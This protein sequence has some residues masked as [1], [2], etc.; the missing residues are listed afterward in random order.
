MGNDSYVQARVDPHIKE[1]ARNVL[2]EL[3]MSMSEAIVVYLK[4]II[5][6]RGIPF[7][8]KL[9]NKATLTAVQELESGKGAT[10]DS[11]DELLEDLEN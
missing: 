4:Q 3:G 7:E 10:F 11:V 9:P 1:Q 2:H 8:L 5:L 6:Q